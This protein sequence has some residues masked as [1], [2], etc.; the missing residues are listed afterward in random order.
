M[1]GGILSR[2]LGGGRR[3]TGTAVGTARRPR[4][5]RTAT[6]TGNREVERGVASVVR[7]L[8][9]RRRGF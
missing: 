6:S 1:V 5:G 7:G 2:V 9:R 3:R 4:T 8:T